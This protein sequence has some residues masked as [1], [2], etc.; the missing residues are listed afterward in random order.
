MRATLVIMAGGKSSRMKRDKALLPFAGYRTLAEYQYQRWSAFFSN[1]YLSSK[2]DKFDFSADIIEDCY[3]ESSPLVALVSI[4]ET[5]DLNEVFVLSVDAPFVTEEIIKRLYTEARA[6][7]SV[8]IAE[9]QKGLEPLCGIYRR[10]ILEEA[11]VFLEQDNHRLQDLL[12]RVITQKVQIDDGQA[13]MNLNHPSEYEKAM[14]FL[15]TD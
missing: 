6:E 2:K 9:S 11:K 14:K 5:L 15:N 1:V 12:K 13:F 8:I 4:F 7:S 3:T 10:T